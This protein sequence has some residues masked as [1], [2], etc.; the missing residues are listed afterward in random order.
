MTLLQK[1]KDGI[2]ETNYIVNIADVK[3]L[4]KELEEANKKITLLENKVTELEL[5]ISGEC[6]LIKE[7]GA[8]YSDNKGGKYCVRCYEENQERIALSSAQIGP[9][10]IF[11]CS[12]CGYDAIY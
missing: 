9:R 3:S 5:I 8:Y 10:N 4:L 12:K 2:K 11:K 7:N 1:I 6:D